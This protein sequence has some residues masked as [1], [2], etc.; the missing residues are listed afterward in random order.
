MFSGF[1]SVAVLLVQVQL[2]QGVGESPKLEQ[3]LVD[4][5]LHPDEVEAKGIGPLPELSQ[6]SSVS[7]GKHEI[8]QLTLGK[9]GQ[10]PDEMGMLEILDV[11]QRLRFGLELRAEPVAVARLPH[12]LDG[13]IPYSVADLSCLGKR[14]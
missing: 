14:L 8:V 11:I 2:G 10:P 9:G 4:Q 3:R 13:N 12:L 6:A 5:G 1:V 7:P